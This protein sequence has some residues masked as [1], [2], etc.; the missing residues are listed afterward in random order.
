[1]Q[2]PVTLQQAD[3]GVTDATQPEIRELQHATALLRDSLKGEIADSGEA[4][5]PSKSRK[6]LLVADAF[7]NP[8]HVHF[9]L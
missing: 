2:F 7:T 6:R 5:G 9:A 8:A 3:A 4:A 1:M